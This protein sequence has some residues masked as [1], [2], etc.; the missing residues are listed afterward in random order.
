A[1][2]EAALGLEERTRPGRGE[3]AG[4]AGLSPREAE[5]LRLIA[6]GRSNQEIA[7]ELFLSVR[8]VERHVTNLYAK[9]GARGRA[10]ATAFAL[11][12]GLA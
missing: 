4:A 3:R 1:E 8:T 12:H 6:V 5:V 2:V 11:R 9:I 10:N 7:R